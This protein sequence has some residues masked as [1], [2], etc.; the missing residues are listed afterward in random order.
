MK[1]ASFKIQPDR[2]GWLRTTLWPISAK[3]NV[4]FGPLDVFML[5]ALVLGTVAVARLLIAH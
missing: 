4:R 5:L 1:R 2:Q 3:Q